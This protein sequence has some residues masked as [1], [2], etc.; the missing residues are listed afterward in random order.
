[1]APKF[2][3]LLPAM[4]R[5]NL[6]KE[7]LLSLIHQDFQDFEVILSNNGAN[8]KIRDAVSHYLENPKIRY[9][10]WADVLSMPDHWE[11][12]SRMAK[13]EYVTVLTDR[14]VLKQNA[15]AEVAKMHT[16]NGLGAPAISWG[17]DLFY[18][19]TKTLH[20]ATYQDEYHTV[21]ESSELLKNA[22]N[23]T[24]E[25]PYAL[26]RGLNSSVKN[27]EIKKIRKTAGAAFASMSPDFSFAYACLQSFDQIVHINKSLM[28]SQ[29]LK[30]SNG[31]NAYHGD[32]TG[33]VQSLKLTEPV[34]K[35]S[36]IKEHFVENS[37]AEDFFASCHIF[38]NVSILSSI[39]LT[40]LF[41]KCYRELD[42]KRATNIIP[43]NRIDEFSQALE[44]ALHQQPPAVIEKVRSELQASKNLSKSIKQTIKK[45]LGSSI[46]KIRFYQRMLTGT[47]TYETALEAAGHSTK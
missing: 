6:I 36:P 14:S 10:E 35:Y 41:V 5:P 20:C 7:A 39:D 9:L 17:W 28:I 30:V 21:L 8:K 3:I 11:Q 25:F 47:K 24:G 32:G 19:D 33:Y 15:L 2:T 13:G 31:G 22:L 4:G 12:I 44:T 40:D 27:E 16:Q 38:N 34:Y 26:P 1:M 46:T 45:T 18:N 42:E 23:I 29:G 43:K 37:I